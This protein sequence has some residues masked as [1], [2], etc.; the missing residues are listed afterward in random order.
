VLLSA[1]GWRESPIH[2]ATEVLT[3]KAQD[4]REAQALAR[5]RQVLKDA[6]YTAEDLDA[7]LRHGREAVAPVPA[8]IRAKG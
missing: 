7:L 3:L 5:V 4:S 2:D 6:R 1:V 8:K